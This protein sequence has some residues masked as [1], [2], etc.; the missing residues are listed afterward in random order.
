MMKKLML[1]L[2]AA[3]SLL[4]GCIAVPVSDGGVYVT[5]TA[6]ATDGHPRRYSRDRD[7]DGVQNRYDRRP[8]NP[9]RY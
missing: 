5:G 9:Y 1:C 2:A 6:R 8:N 4:T 3:S 7:G